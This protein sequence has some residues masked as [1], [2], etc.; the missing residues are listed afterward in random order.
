MGRNPAVRESNLSRRTPGPH[1]RKVVSRE[2]PIQY[3]TQC[4]AADHPISRVGDAIR[5][6]D[7][8]CSHR[9]VPDPVVRHRI[10]DDARRPVVQYSIV[11]CDGRLAP[12]VDDPVVAEGIHHLAT[13]EVQVNAKLG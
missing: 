1:L 4:R 8:F 9:D 11:D 13:A 10:L 12:V 7:A 6:L 3:G 2:I 5:Y